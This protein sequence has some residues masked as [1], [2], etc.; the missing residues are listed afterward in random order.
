ML[1]KLFETPTSNVIT[2]EIERPIMA[3]LPVVAVIG[4]KGGVGA[5]SIAANL[6][7]ILAVMGL[8]TTLID[9]NLQQP[10]MAHMFGKEPEHSLMELLN[11]GAQLDKQVFEA[12][13]IKLAEGELSLS[14]ISPPIDGSAAF[15]AN[16]S[17]LAECLDL[18]KSYS[19]F[20]LID[21]PRH[22]DKYLVTLADKCDKILLVFEAT[23]SGVAACRRWLNIFSEL[24]YSSDKIICVLNRAGSKYTAVEQQ[25]TNY[26]TDELIFRIPNASL[27]AWE[28]NTSGTPIVLA[29][30]N[31]KYSQAL[32]RLAQYLCKSFAE[33]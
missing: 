22:I 32:A 21:L 14:L 15:K 13:S 31:H 12:C 2:K 26:F 3:V 6:A 8:N 4:A 9:A 20:W 10:D 28:S 25:L 33:G 7:A 29:Q 27:P 24:D 16:L 18:V 30:P 5:T 19:Q 23:V 11:R 17:Q 1:K